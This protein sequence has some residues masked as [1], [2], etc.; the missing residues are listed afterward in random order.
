MHGLEDLEARD[1]LERPARVWQ[2]FRERALECGGRDPAL[3]LRGAFFLLDA[4]PPRAAPPRAKAASRPPHSIKQ[5]LC[6]KNRQTPMLRSRR[7]QSRPRGDAAI[8]R[9]FGPARM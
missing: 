5:P 4:S 1:G 8:M 3:A 2:F 6:R 7:A 9:A